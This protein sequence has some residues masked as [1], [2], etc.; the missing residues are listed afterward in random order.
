MPSTNASQPFKHIGVVGAGSMGSMMVLAFAEIGLDVSVW[1]VEKANIEKI[2][3]MSKKATTSKAKVE[4]FTDLKKFTKNLEGQNID[5]RKLFM[6]SVTHGPPA[7]SILGMLKCDLQKG[8]IIIDG[9]NEN[10]RRTERRQ[11]ECKAMGVDWIGMG[12]SGGYHGDAKAI[13]LVMPFLEQYA[14]KAPKDGT[15]CVTRIG[16]DGSG[17]V[18]KMVHNGTE[19]GELCKNFLINIGADILRTKKTSEGDEKGEG[20]S[21]NNG[22]PLWSLMEA[23][24]R[25]VSC[26][27]LAAV[28][29]M[30]IAS[31]NRGE[32]QHV[33]ERLKIPAP[34]PIG[35]SMD[36]KTLVEKLRRAVYATFLASFCQGLELIARASEDEG[37]EINMADCLQIW[38]AGYIIES[39]HIADLLQP[40]LAEKPVKNMKVF[41][42]VS[43]ELHSNYEPL[44]E[45]V[46]Q[47][48][49]TDQY[50]PSITATLEYLKYEGGVIIPTKFMEAQMD[51]FGAH[52]Y[53]KPGIPGE[54]PGPVKKG[55]HHYEWKAA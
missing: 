14:A 38:R 15:P 7:D 53:N 35:S 6:F 1:D 28:H 40:A 9:G 17:N 55:P 37:W 4:G 10:Y 51:Y 29:W 13:A 2:A 45:I 3:D 32:R 36:Q 39:E 44:K 8:D 20:A 42:S 46:V 30:R 27:T 47:G 50:I 49:M 11:K 24:D 5:D 16:P 33:A 54:D 21:M 12:V 19:G 52:G 41:D 31:G 18:V 48:A 43:Q 23:A 25:H 22:T 26:P 34:K